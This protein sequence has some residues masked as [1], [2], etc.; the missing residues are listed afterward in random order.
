MTQIRNCNWITWSFARRDNVVPLAKRIAF[1]NVYGA[2]LFI[3]YFPLQFIFICVNLAND[4]EPFWRCGWWDKT[5]DGL[6][7]DQRF[8]LPVFCDVAEKPMLDFVPFRSPGREMRHVNFQPRLVCNLLQFI[9]PQLYPD[10]IY[11][12]GEAGFPVKPRPPFRWLGSCDSGPS[13]PSWRAQN[14]WETF[15]L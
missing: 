3:C 1:L 9:F 2:H 13:R 11:R 7:I 15:F 12:C 4:L 14:F 10:W 8:S 6:N 5:D